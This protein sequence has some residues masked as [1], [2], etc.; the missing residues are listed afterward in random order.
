MGKPDEVP[1]TVTYRRRSARVAHIEENS[2]TDVVATL[3]G[4]FSQRPIISKWMLVVA[5]LV[6]LITCQLISWTWVLDNF[7]RCL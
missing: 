6:V 5:A 4:S 7:K 3:P 2:A 1:F